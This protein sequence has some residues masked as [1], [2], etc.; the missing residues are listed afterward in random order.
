MEVSDDTI[1]CQFNVGKG[2]AILD[3]VRR[4]LKVEEPTLTLTLIPS[5]HILL[6]FWILSL[7]TLGK[8]G[9]TMVFPFEPSRIITFSQP[10]SLESN[11]GSGWQS[12]KRS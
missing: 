5:D 3:I 6:V 1:R 8:G 2:L 4:M 9:W 11:F 12:D 7:L 10:A